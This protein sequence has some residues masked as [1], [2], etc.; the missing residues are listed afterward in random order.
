MA[1]SR[2]AAS[3]AKC[4]RISTERASGAIRVGRILLCNMPW[5]LQA[6]PARYDRMTSGHPHAG[7]TVDVDALRFGV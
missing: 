5:K 1:A 2:R 4:V 6:L 7:S 3:P